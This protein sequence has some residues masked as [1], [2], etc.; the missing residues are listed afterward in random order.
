MVPGRGQGRGDHLIHLWGNGIR[1]TQGL[2]DFA[3]RSGRVLEMTTAATADQVDKLIVG[4][5]VQFGYGVF[6][7]QGNAGRAENVGERL[8]PFP[9]AALE[10]GI[11][12]EAIF[13]PRQSL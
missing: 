8:D 13:L 2:S 6:G 4:H 11:G 12:L 9:V 10:I 1:G 5:L 7:E 3:G